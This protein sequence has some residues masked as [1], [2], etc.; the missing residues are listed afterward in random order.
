MNSASYFREEIL[1]LTFY[2]PW[3]KRRTQNSKNVELVEVEPGWFYQ[4]VCYMF[5]WLRNL[6][7]TSTKAEGSLMNVVIKSWFLP[8]IKL[9]WLLNCLGV[10]SLRLPELRNKCTFWRGR[11]AEVV[12]LPCHWQLLP[13]LFLEKWKVK[14]KK[15]L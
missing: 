7:P 2:I 5:R 6:V 10:Y 11:E 15:D 4:L 1:F 8:L 13:I 9:I 3:E 14:Y 12:V